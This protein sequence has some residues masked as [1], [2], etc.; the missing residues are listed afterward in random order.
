MLFSPSLK[1][2]VIYTYV[3]LV[4]SDKLLTIQVILGQG[5]NADLRC[6]ITP[7][8]SHGGDICY[9]SQKRAII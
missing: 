7:W 4:V 9:G 6:L 3:V 8:A 1:F 2:A 5:N